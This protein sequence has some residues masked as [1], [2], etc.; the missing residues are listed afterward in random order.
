MN[1][2]HGCASLTLI[3]RLSRLMTKDLLCVPTPTS[4][5]DLSLG[6]ELKLQ[7]VSEMS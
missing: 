3:D 6:G 4:S 2:H 5:T 1:E 7:D